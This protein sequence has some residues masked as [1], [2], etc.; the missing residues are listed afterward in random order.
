MDTD[1]DG[2]CNTL[3]ADD[4]GDGVADADDAFPLDASESVDTDGDGTGNN[5][6]LDDD[7]DGILDA[8]EL[9]DETDP[10]DAD[11]YDR[12]RKATQPPVD[13]ALYIDSQ[14]CESCGVQ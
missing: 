10:L 2:Q 1:G 6:D 4:D 13:R 12:C 11:S 7:G 14:C 3:D 5:A 8:D 9:A